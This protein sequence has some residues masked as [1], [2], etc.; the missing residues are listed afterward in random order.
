MTEKMS[1]N[2]KK[3]KFTYYDTGNVPGDY[4]RSYTAWDNTIYLD[5]H[6]GG[7]NVQMDGKDLA[8][9][10]NRLFNLLTESKRQDTIN[11]STSEGFALR[12]KEGGLGKLVKEE[13]EKK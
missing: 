4:L 12:V 3:I 1:P 8:E 10:Q 5:G 11:A 13:K 7:H 9:M 6:I 2:H